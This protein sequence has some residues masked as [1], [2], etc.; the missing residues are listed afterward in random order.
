[1]AL[2]AR[3]VGVP[4]EVAVGAPRQAARVQIVVD[5]ACHVLAAGTVG[6][7]VAARP[8]RLVA[9]LADVAEGLLVPSRRAVGHAPVQLRVLVERAG[10][11]VRQQEGRAF[12]A[13]FR[14]VAETEGTAAGAL[15]AVPG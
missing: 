2:Y 3:V 14:V 12:G 8:A 9:L 6:R 10:R 15:F 1:M 7:V 5:D 4:A 13:V 11:S